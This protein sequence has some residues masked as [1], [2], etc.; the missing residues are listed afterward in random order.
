MTDAAQEQSLDIALIANAL[1]ERARTHPIGELQTI[2]TKLKRLGRRPSRDIFAP[3]TIHAGWACHLGGRT[4]LQFNIGRE[5]RSGELEFRHGVA[6]SLDTSQAL[7][8]ITVLIPKMEHFNT[9]LQIYSD[10]YSDMRMWY[11]QKKQPSGDF[12]P[13]SV[14][15]EMHK[16]FE[17]GTFV[18]FGKRQPARS[19]DYEAVLDDLDRLLPLYQYVESKG[20]WQPSIESF[21]FRAGCSVKVSE[22]T[23]SLA[24]RK[25][26]INLRHNMLQAALTTRL[27]ERFGKDNVADEHQSGLGTKIDAV[28]R[29]EVN[30]YWYYEI[31]TALSPRACLREAIGQVLEYAYWP[32]VRGREA[33]RLIVCG[34]TPL[35]D[36]GR[37]YLLTLTK[38]FELPIEYEQ[39]IAG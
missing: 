6:F 33:T 15:S 13:A 28:V 18:F 24:E 34:E 1:N 8:D 16:L 12:S 4:E 26:N 27:I 37:A 20:V 5:M 9:Y 3:K 14:A 22:T 30:E 25:L 23:A 31:K 11:Y 35:D 29:R 32:G 19:I 38:R 36:D 17:K 21:Q 7:P 2:R 39:I 10:S